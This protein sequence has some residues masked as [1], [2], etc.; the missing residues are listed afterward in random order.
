MAIFGFVHILILM[1]VVLGL[2]GSVIAGIYLTVRLNRRT[3]G[4][5]S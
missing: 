2:F 1:A 5:P 4:S 3:G